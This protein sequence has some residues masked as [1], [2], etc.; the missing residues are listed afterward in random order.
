MG[1]CLSSDTAKK[2]PS[3]TSSSAR[4]AHEQGTRTWSTASGANVKSS[5][6]ATIQGHEMHISS[7]VATGRPL[8]FLM[9]DS[10]SV[11]S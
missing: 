10:D 4:E 9:S 8:V 3:S 11:C 6:D 7:P 1:G 2:H 5:G